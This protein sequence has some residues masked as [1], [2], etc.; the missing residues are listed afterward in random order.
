MAN[1][2][3]IR[4]VARVGFSASELTKPFV[5]NGLVDPIAQFSSHLISD[6]EENPYR[7]LTKVKLTDTQTAN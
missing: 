1:V 6:L 2:L 3:C 5:L 7:F 4:S